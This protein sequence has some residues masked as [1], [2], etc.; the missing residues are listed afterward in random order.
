VLSTLGV[1]SSEYLPEVDAF[2]AFAS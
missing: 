2:K 1:D